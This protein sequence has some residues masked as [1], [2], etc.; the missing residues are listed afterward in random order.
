[1]VHTLCYAVLTYTT[2]GDVQ[3]R[4]PKTLLGWFFRDFALGTGVFTIILLFIYGPNKGFSIA[5]L[6]GII[7]GIGRVF[8]EWLPNHCQPQILFKCRSC[9]IQAKERRDELAGIKLLFLIRKIIRRKRK[10]G[11][12]QLLKMLDRSGHMKG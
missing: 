11:D 6:F 8:S 4:Q 9:H 2:K 12:T 5:I 1:M 3:M 10:D 7:M